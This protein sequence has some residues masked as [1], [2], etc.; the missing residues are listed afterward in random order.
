MRIGICGWTMPGWG[1]ALTIE[2]ALDLAKASGFTVLEPNIFT[3]GQ[4]SITTD[5]ATCERWRE[6]A[7]VRGMA[8]ETVASFMGW[9]VVTNADPAVREQAIANNAAALERAQ[10]MGASGLLFIPGGIF[11]PWNASFPAV[12]YDDAFRW[13]GEAIARLAPVAERLGVDLCV[14]NVMNG[15]FYSPLEFAAVIDAPR[16]PR[17]GAY[18]DVGNVMIHHQH[19]QHWIRILGQ[20]I[21][22]VHFKDFQRAVGNMAGYVELQAG[23]APWAEIMVALRAISYDGTLMAE[24]DCKDTAA[25]ARAGQ[26][27][28]RIVAL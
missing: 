21:K 16:S 13:A 11:M 22:R 19:P 25:V 15:L 27:M 6:A 28:A 14:E 8:I 24:V 3:T 1:G 10:W 12:P 17:V 20:R 7:R 5:R 9:D 26:A 23:D 18:F 4:L 2:Q